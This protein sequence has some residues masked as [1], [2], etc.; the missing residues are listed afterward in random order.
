MPIG[1]GVLT[2][3][4]L[5]RSNVV[6]LVMRARHAGTWLAVSVARRPQML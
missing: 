1:A 4:K 2:R 3:I 6:P 5:S